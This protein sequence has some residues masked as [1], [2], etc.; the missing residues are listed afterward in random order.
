[1]LAG[2]YGPVVVVCTVVGGVLGLL[3]DVGGAVVGTVVAATVDDGGGFVVE[4]SAT[5]VVSETDV[6]VESFDPLCEGRYR[7]V[8]RDENPGTDS[9][10]PDANVQPIG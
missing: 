8:G 6:E 1:M 9:P 5:T 4:V 7:D 3:V 2:A 10:L